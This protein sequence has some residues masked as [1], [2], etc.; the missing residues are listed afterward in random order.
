L[1]KSSY[2]FPTSARIRFRCDAGDNNDDVYV[3]A[4]TWRATTSV[5]SSEPVTTAMPSRKDPN[6][7]EMMAPGAQ[8]QR[9]VTEL[10]QNFPNPFNPRTTI[11]FTLASEAHVTLDVFDVSGRRVASLMNETQGAGQHTVDFDASALASGVYFYRL[12]AGGVVQQRKM[13]LL[14]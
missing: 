8:P 5:L 12:T 6:I 2:A 14:K 4:I 3:D 1:P 13:I 11:A 7:E 10:G 9:F